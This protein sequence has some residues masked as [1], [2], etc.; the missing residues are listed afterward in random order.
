MISSTPFRT[1]LPLT[2]RTLRTFK[3]IL[4][5]WSPPVLFLS[6]ILTIVSPWFLAAFT[7]ALL[8]MFYG[9]VGSVKLFG[10]LYWM[11]KRDRYWLNCGI[12][13]MHQT[14]SPWRS[15]PGIY[16]TVLKW[17]FLVGLA[18]KNPNMDET[19][20]TLS[21]LKGRYLD[22]EPKEIGEW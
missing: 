12:G 20:G 9:N 7:Y 1:D 21:A 15:G 14:H 13:H 19:E 4:P 17:T 10:P 8:H 6:L 11:T 22:L 16:V 3:S 18:F 2:T 5:Y